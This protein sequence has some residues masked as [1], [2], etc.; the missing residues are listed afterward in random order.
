MR[1]DVVW[2]GEMLPQD[3]LKKAFAASEICDVFLSIGTSAVVHPAASLPVA[4]KEA[5]AYVVEINPERTVISD[6][7]DETILGKSGEV[8]PRLVAELRDSVSRT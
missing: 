2:F 6:D 4:A 5:G 7:L 8:L 1:P 3:V